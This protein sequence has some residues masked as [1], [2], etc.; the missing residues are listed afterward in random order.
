MV[1]LCQDPGSSISLTPTLIDAYHML[2][3]RLMDI[4]NLVATPTVVFQFQAQNHTSDALFFFFF[5]RK[6]HIQTYA[7]EMCTHD[8]AKMELPK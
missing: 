4:W 8:T 1:M 3:S 7:F 6:T 2:A 5:S